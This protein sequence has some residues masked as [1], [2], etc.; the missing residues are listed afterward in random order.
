VINDFKDSVHEIV[1]VDG[2]STDGTVEKLA[3]L[4]DRFNLKLV[5]GKFQGYGD[6]IINGSPPRPAISSPSLREMPPSGPRHG[7]AL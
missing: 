5:Q 6:A 7:Q 2:G 3:E 4:K 1:V